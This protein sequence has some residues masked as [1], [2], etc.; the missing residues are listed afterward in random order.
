MLS[1]HNGKVILHLLQVEKITNDLI[2]LFNSV[3]SHNIYIVYSPSDDRKVNLFYGE[4]VLFKSNLDLTDI[5]D[6]FDVAGIIVHGLHAEFAE[7]IAGIKSTIKIAWMVWGFDVYN[8]PRIRAQIYASCTYKYLLKQDPFFRIKLKIA[9]LDS[10][11]KVLSKYVLKKVDKHSFVLAA[12]ARVDYFCTYISEDYE[13]FSEFYPNSIKFLYSTFLNLEQYLAGDL[14]SRVSADAENII[15]GNSSYP[16]NNHLDVFDKLKAHQHSGKIVVPL[17]YGKGERYKVKVIEEGRKLYREKFLPLTDFMPREEYLNIL[18]SCSCGVFYHYRQQAM[19]NILAL[20]YMGCRLYF[21]Y[22]NPVYRYFKRIGVEV[23]ELEEDFAYYGT[24]ILDS[25]VA[26][27]NR[28]ILDDLFSKKQVSNDI[29][30]L[31]NTL[32]DVK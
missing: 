12:H 10:F 28:R 20:L 19:G 31:V 18:K 13:Y 8:L 26:E 21:S 29:E 25:E 3:Y 2:N 1:P 24:A 11:R 7:Q 15:I 9:Q 27:S 5:L 30:N 14:H 17:S 16:E 4:N 23:F 32:I 22:R 6:K